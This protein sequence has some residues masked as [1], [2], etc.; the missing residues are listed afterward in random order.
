MHVKAWINSEFQSLPKMSNSGL[1]SY[2][3]YRYYALSVVDKIRVCNMIMTFQIRTYFWEIFYKSNTVD[4]FCVYIASSQHLAGSEKS[5]SYAIPRLRLRFKET[6]SIHVCRCSCYER[7]QNGRLS[8]TE[9][10]KDQKLSLSGR[11]WDTCSCI[12]F[13]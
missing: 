12:Y 2:S 3:Q 1:K 13:I 9:H 4:F 5:W 7:L 11:C 8:L 6:S 10:S